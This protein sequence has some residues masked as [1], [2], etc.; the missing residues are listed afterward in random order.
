MILLHAAAGCIIGERRDKDVRTMPISSFLAGSFDS[1]DRNRGEEYFRERRVKLTDV[2]EA[3]IDAKVSGTRRYDVM[4]DIETDRVTARCTCPYSDGEFVACKHIWAAIRAAEAQ[5]FGSEVKRPMHLEVVN[6]DG[7]NFEEF[8][9]DEFAEDARPRRVKTKRKPKAKRASWEDQFSEVERLAKPAPA[10][11][12][13]WQQPAR[14]NGEQRWIYLLDIPASDTAK[15]L[16]INLASQPRKK[17]GEWGV[18]KKLTGGVDIAAQEDAVDRRIFLLA[19]GASRSSTTFYPDYYSSQHGHLRLDRELAEVLVPAMQESGRFFIGKLE[20]NGAQG[21]SPLAFDDGPAWELALDVNHAEEGL[22]WRLQGRLVRGDESVPADQAEILIPG[23]AL[24]NGTLRRF[25][26]TGG[27]AW[28][29]VLRKAKAV[30]VP[31]ARGAD[32]V[33]RLIAMPRPARTTMP[34]ELKFE[35]TSLTPRPRLVVK[36]VTSYGRAVLEA[37]LS[38][39]YDDV[40]VSAETP[41]S[42]IVQADRRR[43]IRRDHSV[44]SHAE[45]AFHRMG[46][47]EAYIN[48]AR[49]HEIAVNKL[50]KA[51]LEATALGWLVEAEGTLY[52]RAGHFELNLKS[53]TDWFDLSGAAD[54]EGKSVPLPELLAALRSG[55]K[56][57]TLDDG[58][59]GMLP[60]EWL[61]KYGMIAHLGTPQ[62]DSLRFGKAQVGVLDA[63]L[64]SRPEIGFDKQFEKARGQLRKFDGLDAADPPTAFKGELRGYQ[65]EG[66][67]WLRFLRKFGLGGCLADDMGLG[68]TV[69]VLAMLAGKRKG[70]ALVVVPKSL[71]FN[72]KQEAA[73]FAPKLKVLDH[74]GLGRSKT[75]ESFAEHDIVLTTYGTLRRDA[76]LISEFRFDT[77]VLDE[78]QAAKNANTDTAKAVKLIQADHRLALSGTP[79][80][81]HLG[82][83]WTLFDFL[84]PGMLGRAGAFGGDA[85][86]LRNPD[87]ETRELLAKALKPYILRRKKTEVAKDLPEKT[88]QT[89][90]CELDADQRRLYDE[91][92]DHYR[93]SLLSKVDELGLKRTKIQVLAA[94]LRLRQAACHPGLIDEKRIGDPS[95]KLDALLP[96]IEEVVEEGHKVLVFSQFT[97]F[98]AIAKTRF[99][100]AGLTYEYLDGQ[101][102]DRAAKVDRFQN[103]PDCKLFLVSLKAGGVGLN[104]T[105]A[106]Y[107]YLLDPWWNPAAEAQAIDR[108]HRIGQNKPVFAYRLIAKNTVEEKVL[109]LQ[110]SKK[111][112]AD[113][114]LGGDGRLITELKREDLEMLLS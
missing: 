106:D 15:K 113:S 54:F 114:I 91:L 19:N 74:T 31:L 70:A 107:V 92:R 23:F 9:D 84:N 6:G 11:S 97:S 104:L 29:P 47:R 90:H 66:L 53:E 20:P 3:W 96:L 88:E 57:I 1:R 76:A 98:L 33:S 17:N 95:A 56:T 16:N 32:L 45:A 30:E 62:G 79:I 24:W 35:E 50:S 80:E 2:N 68:K 38:F 85:G 13:H 61:K 7:Q 77:C 112:L 81:N 34:D 4:V 111:A 89:L 10:P 40:S 109:Q 28:V 65:R 36:K 101:T 78:S 44:E 100:A 42:N 105:A 49:S 83:L 60:E 75:N 27:L 43:V 12:S 41:G 82:E 59:V 25:H 103:D 8:E 46:A 48:Q 99:D 93:M 52:R 94:L 5:G 67:G 63:L 86:S 72:W 58:T 37:K 64:L 39:L 71:I 102:R 55:S 21:Y 73:R 69:Q 22:T 18:P 26:D 110:Q 87:A 14:R 108:S 51:V